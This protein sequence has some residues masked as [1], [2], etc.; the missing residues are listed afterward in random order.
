M[1]R[2]LHGLKG[3]HSNLLLI[4]FVAGYRDRLEVPI[5]ENTPHEE[6]LEASMR[7]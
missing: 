5:I 6:E 7:E 2:I 3:L 4:M 1:V